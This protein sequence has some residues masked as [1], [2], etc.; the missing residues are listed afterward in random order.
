MPVCLVNSSRVGCVVLPPTLATSMYSGQFAKLR[1]PA[2]VLPAQN[3]ATAS[4]VVLAA[5]LLAPDTPQ[6][7]RRALAPAAPAPPRK[8]RRLQ[9]GSVMPRSSDGSIGEV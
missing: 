8:A 1:M 3:W 4:G 2:L 5:G 7:A 9:R 6:A